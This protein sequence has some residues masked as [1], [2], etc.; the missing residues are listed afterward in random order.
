MSIT[1][2]NRNRQEQEWNVSI[3]SLSLNEKDF[4]IWVAQP[5]KY[6]VVTRPIP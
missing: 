3:T 5:A 4:K 1:V 6:N 2:K